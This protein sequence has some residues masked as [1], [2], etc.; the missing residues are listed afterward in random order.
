MSE[1]IKLYSK[2]C[3]FKKQIYEGLYSLLYT[4]KNSKTGQD[5]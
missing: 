1:F 4:D 5:T 3:V 2:I